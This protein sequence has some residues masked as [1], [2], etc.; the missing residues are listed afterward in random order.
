MDTQL[1][2]TT[3]VEKS[4]HIDGV[5]AI[6]LGGSRSRG[7]HTQK[8][9]IDLCI[10]YHPAH[11]LD[12]NA[13]ERV[14]AEIDDSHRAGLITPIG[15]WG[16][17]ING[18]GWLTV[19]SQAV[20]FLYR[21]LQ[22]VESV[23]DDCLAG[24]VDIFYQPGHPHGFVSAIYLAEVA[25]CRPLWEADG[26]LSE[27][28]SRVQPYPQALQQALIQKFAWEI[29]F[30]LQ[31]GRK[32]IA[33]NDVAYA[34]GC[35]FRSVACML[36]V[37]FALNEEYWLNEKGAL[38]IADKF[39]IRPVNLKERIEAAFALLSAHGESIARAIEVLEGVNQEITMS[40]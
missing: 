27:L 23:I 25:V 2:T 7:T 33:R 5:S 13:L 14:T 18:G 22:K 20:D 40:L 4:K 39:R 34:A 38:L 8:S 36:Q 29:D 37:L 30:A 11:P 31:T 21:D 16:P 26:K 15:G 17:W 19:R 3:I 1:I 28:K 9:D 10:Y 12:L 6:V 24:Q 35:C 32:S